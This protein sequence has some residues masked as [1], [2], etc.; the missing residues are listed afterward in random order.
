MELLKEDF[1]QP[2]F[3]GRAGVITVVA[4]SELNSFL[5]R[6]KKITKILP[7]EG[8]AKTLG[9]FIFPYCNKSGNPG[10]HLAKSR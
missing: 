6:K 4:V 8:L 7:K 9:R 10:L 5:H 1:K 2:Q 3:M